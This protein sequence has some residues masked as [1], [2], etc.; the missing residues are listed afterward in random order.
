MKGNYNE[1]HVS[2]EVFYKSVYDAAHCFNNK[3]TAILGNVNLAKRLIDDD[4]RA[5]TRLEEAERACNEA[6]IYSHYL[7]KLLNDFSSSPTT[8]VCQLEVK[9][10]ENNLA[11]CKHNTT[12][13]CAR[14]LKLLFIDDDDNVRTTMCELLSISGY[15]VCQAKDGQEAINLYKEAAITDKPY[16]LLIVDLHLKGNFSGIDTV[17]SILQINQ[18]VKA[19]VISGAIL[20]CAMQQYKLYG[21]YDR[22][23]KPFTI[24]ELV[25][26]I[27]SMFP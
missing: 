24:D 15:E 6:Q 14:Q 5:Y 12:S 27:N 10:I 21:F 18:N 7:L 1:H 22:I 3:L 16:D 20:D 4:N 9:H 8:I 26:K 2:A 11:I 19:I 17:N 23:E 25:D 13:M